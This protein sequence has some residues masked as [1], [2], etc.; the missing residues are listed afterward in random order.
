MRSSFGGVG[1]LCL[2]AWTWSSAQVATGPL[3]SDGL[4]LY[5]VDCPAE[6]AGVEGA[7]CLV[8][9]YTYVGWRVFHRTCHVCHAQDAVGSDFAPNLV[10]RVAQ[11][12]AERFLAAM[13]NGY[14]G[15]AEMP[16][17]GRD[18]E[19]RP[20]YFELWAYLSARAAGDLPP[21]EPQRAPN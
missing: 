19:V 6:S 21:G 4:P 8:D 13:E 9:R 7:S 5:I 10:S 18:P 12:D 15:E 11:M 20:Y 17:W 16:A 2:I 3:G 1:A 14:S